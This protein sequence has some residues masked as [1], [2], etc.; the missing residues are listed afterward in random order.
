VVADLPG[1]SFHVSHEETV[2]NAAA[3]V[4][5]GRRPQSGGG[6][7]RLDAVRAILDAAIR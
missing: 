5:A 6:R 2:R 3:L 7:K 4:R 1:M